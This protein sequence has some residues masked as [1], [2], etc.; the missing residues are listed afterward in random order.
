LKL[1]RDEI[2]ALITQYEKEVRAYRDESLKMCWYM[3][4][5]L[6]YDEAIMLNQSEREIVAKIVKDNM[7][8]TK[9]SGLPFF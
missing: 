3:R 8:A 9:K 1:S 5:G 4:G 2:I 7:E 6:T